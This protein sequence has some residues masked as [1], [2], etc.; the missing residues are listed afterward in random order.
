[1]AYCGRMASSRSAKRSGSASRQS[2]ICRIHSAN[3]V[4]RRHARR[5][6][7][8][9]LDQRP[10]GA[11]PTSPTIGQVGRLVLVDL[12]RVDVD[13][14]DL[15]VLGELAD[16]A[17]DAVVEADAQGQQQVGLVD[18]VVGVDGAVHAEHLQAEEMLAGKAAQAVQRQ[19]HGDAGLLGERLQVR[20]PRSAAMMPPPA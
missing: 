7:V 18:G 12:R 4:A 2:S 6:L 9:H 20:R 1:M 14:H 10:A 15:A 17:G 3:G 13:V 16:L 19:G 8:Q 11:W 5:L